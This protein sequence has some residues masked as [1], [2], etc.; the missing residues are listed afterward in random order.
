M[1][2]WHHR[3]GVA[4]YCLLLI[5]PLA[6]AA[7]RWSDSPQGA[8]LVLAPWAQSWPI[9]IG[10]IALA[11]LMLG[12]ASTFAVHL[13]YRRWRR[14]HMLLG[15]A[16]VLGLLHGQVI[17]A[18]PS[19]L[20]G[21]LAVTAIVLGWRLLL[22]DRGLAAFPYRVE[23]VEPRAPGL[24]ELTLAPSSTPLAALPGQ[25]VLVAFHEGPG[26]RGCREFHPF[27]LSEI[28]RSGI[29]RLG[30]KALGPC[31][32]RMQQVPVGTAVRLQG[33]F[34]TFRPGAA[35]A[36]QLWIAGGIGI[37][38]FIAALRAG[39]CL[40]STTLLYFFRAQM[41]GAYIEEL[42]ARAASDSRFELFAVASGGTMPDLT[43]PLDRVTRLGERQMFVCGPHGMMQVVRAELLKRGVHRDSIHSEIF[44]FRL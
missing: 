32:A 44:D 38:P 35:S 19:P 27:T 16:V 24:V 18:Q 8:W 36:P 40:V 4:A 29:V 12:L 26:Y 9:S 39:P 3:G 15:A 21:L 17:V 43:Q 11:M 30:V 34:G 13:P 20:L 33:P 7:E 6:L 1:Y 22:G 10:W 41:D 14:L 23:R 28:H 42:E 37:A 25:F 5:H 31:T 2:R